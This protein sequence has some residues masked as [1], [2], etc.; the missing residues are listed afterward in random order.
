MPVGQDLPLSLPLQ[1]GARAAD[2]SWLL[3]K[4]APEP[5]LG[6]G[7][8]GG[9]APAVGRVWPRARRRWGGATPAALGARAPMCGDKQDLDL[10]LKGWSVGGV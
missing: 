2:G 8:Q 9:A 7:V 1:L 3:Q 10:G 4:G 5:G 6:P